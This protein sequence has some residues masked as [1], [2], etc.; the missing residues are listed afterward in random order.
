MARKQTAKNR[1]KRH[2]KVSKKDARSHR[3][4][5][6]KPRVS[7]KTR[8]SS[9]KQSL[10]MLEALLGS[11]ARARILRFL[12]RHPDAAYNL[13]TLSKILLLK[14]P[15]VARECLALA[16][17]GI[18]KSRSGGS[19]KTYQVSAAFPFSGELR[20]ISVHSHA[21]SNAQ[22][23]SELSKKIHPKLV[24]ISGSFLNIPGSPTDLFV[25]ADRVSEKQLAS[26]MKQFEAQLGTELRWSAFNTNEFIYRWKMFDRFLK[27]I[28][29]STHEI[30][31][32]KVPK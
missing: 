11:P 26:A 6:K 1:R 3:R 21:L 5:K 2:K 20:A 28:F 7:S 30:L 27:S 9:P 24:V 25:V 17:L 32:G 10:P 18:L 22:I 29:E 23:L 8:Q 14:T 4:P 13:K 31:L 19:R 12:Y 15:S 16:R